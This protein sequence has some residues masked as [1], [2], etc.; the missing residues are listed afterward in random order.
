METSDDNCDGGDRTYTS[1]DRAPG[2]PQLQGPEDSARELSYPPAIRDP[3]AGPL[4]CRYVLLGG[5][6]RTLLRN[7]V[8]VSPRHPCPA[9]DPE[10]I[11][12]REVL[13]DRHRESVTCV[14]LRTG[15]QLK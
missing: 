6:R 11:A 12:T 9:R 3:F 8:P 1:P 7:G 2:H 5:D 10:A 4:N 14:C 13:N 15:K